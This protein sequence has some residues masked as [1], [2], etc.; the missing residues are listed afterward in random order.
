M[1]AVADT[2][3]RSQLLP[4]EAVFLANGMSGLPSP[5]RRTVFLVAQLCDGL[6]F[7]RGFGRADDLAELVQGRVRRHILPVFV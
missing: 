5:P 7:L 6:H 1:N 2:I 4:S 3:L